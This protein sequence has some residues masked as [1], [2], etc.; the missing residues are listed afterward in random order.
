MEE[1]FINLVIATAAVGNR[2][3]WD[4]AP[5][6]TNRDERL[7]NETKHPYAVCDRTNTDFQHHTGGLG[8]PHIATVTVRTYAKTRKESVSTA[9]TIRDGIVGT[10]G[11]QAGITVNHLLIRDQRHPYVAPPDGTEKGTYVVECD[12]EIAFEQ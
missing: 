11:T 9:E 5:Q 3:Y 6:I 4:H 10:T 8:G 12:Y 7:G 2:A 1:A